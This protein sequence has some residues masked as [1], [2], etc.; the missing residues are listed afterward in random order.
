MRRAVV[1]T[2][3][4]RAAAGVYE[5]EAGPALVA[6]LAEAGFDVGEPVVIP[7]GRS[8][9]A[10]AIVA[11][12]ERADLVLTTGGTG[13]H[14]TDLTPEGTRDVLDRE[15]PGI[16]EALRAASLDITP[17]A[18]LSRGAAGLRGR[19]LVVNLPGSPKAAVEN[20][21]VLRAVLD[22]AL[23]QLADGDHPA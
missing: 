22:H 18:M 21:E 3:S 12:C 13:L 1:I 6:L 17:M 19:T 9:V 16:V 7:D 5:D 11:A 14:P 4:S 20:A 23:D 10:G 15:A 2:V 8:E